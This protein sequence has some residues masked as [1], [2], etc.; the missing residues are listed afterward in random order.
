MKLFKKILPI[1]ILFI[2]VF[3]LTGCFLLPGN[4]TT[5]Y[6]KP[7][8]TIDYNKIVDSIYSDVYD[9]VERELYDKIYQE[10]KSEFID[11]TVDVDEIQN[12]ILR[13][14]SEAQSVSVGV[15]ALS[16]NALGEEITGSLG[17]GVIIEKATSDGGDKAFRYYVV[18]NE[19]VVS[20]YSRYRVL[21]K[22]ESYIPLT[23]VGK[24]KTTDLAL[25]Y[26]DS[27]REYKVATL[28]SST[29]AKIGEIVLAVGNPKGQTLYGSVTMGILGGKDRHLIDNNVTNTIVSYLQ[30]DAAINSGN[31]GGGLFNLKGEVIGINSAK[32]TSSEI[33]GLNFAIP[34]DL[35]KEVLSE[36]KTSGSYSG[37]VSF[38]ITV[39]SVDDLTQAGRT[40]YNV[41]DNVNEGVLVEG[42]EEGKSSFGILEKND[43]IIEADGVRVVTTPDLSGVLPGHRVGDKI[44]LK[45]IRSTK[46]EETG[47]ITSEIVT[48]EITFKR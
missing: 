48:V 43:I 32:Y 2:S 5:E 27:D 4:R 44:K 26:F 39:I 36:L 31:S 21:F 30:H 8:S 9:K 1:F 34:I 37:K 22:D 15:S 19:H 17:S 14:A 3:M 7:E 18:T 46:N 33:E 29:D 11:G 24:D 28:G 25:L 40:E 16:V 23:L 41:P 42:V 13:I 10:V 6:G 45:V 12:R 47:E 38:G 35:A 20:D